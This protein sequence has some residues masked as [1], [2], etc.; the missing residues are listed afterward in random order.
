MAT[1]IQQ[2]GSAG[3]SKSD[4]ELVPVRVI[5]SKLRSGL[6]V[7]VQMGCS[8]HCINVGAQLSER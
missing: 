5:I 3:E 8:L 4:E 2:S 1:A 7:S 6:G